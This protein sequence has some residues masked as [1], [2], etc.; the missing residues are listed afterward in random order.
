MIYVY[1]SLVAMTS[2]YLALAS[3]RRAHNHKNY[4]LSVLGFGVAIELTLASVYCSLHDRPVEASAAL[5]GQVIFFVAL[6]KFRV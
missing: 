6:T 5:I 1:E 2:V 4:F 3:I